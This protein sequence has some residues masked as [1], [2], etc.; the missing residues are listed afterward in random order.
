MEIET[1]KDSNETEALPDEDDDHSCTRL[2][3]TAVLVTAI[4]DFVL[5]NQILN[6]STGS[7][8]VKV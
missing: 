6:T 1:G 8:N 4:S 5:T 3:H 7:Y 2:Q